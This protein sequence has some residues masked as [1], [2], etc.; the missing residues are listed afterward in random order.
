MKLKIL[1][2]SIA[3]MCLIIFCSVSAET[4]G[5]PDVT[6]HEAK[7]LEN[8]VNLHIEWQSVNPVTQV[9]VSMPNVEKEFP[10]DSYDNKRNPE[11][12]SGEMNVTLNLGFFPVQTF[13]YVIQ[14]QDELRVKSQPVT[15]QISPSSLSQTGQFNQ[16]TQPYPSST[17]LYQSGQYGQYYQSTP[18]YQPVQSG[19][20]GQPS[21][22]Q[23]SVMQ[24]QIQQ[25]VTQPPAQTNKQ[26]TGAVTMIISPFSVA[27]AGAMWRVDG[28]V[29]KKSG[30]TMT[31]VVVG[32][33]A[34]DF[35]DVS[36]WKKPEPQKIMIET[37]QN[38]STAA[39]YLK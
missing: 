27:D 10:V 28:G 25:N 38:V 23:P 20:S 16:T 12:Y 11:G 14:L 21:Q 19:Q 39:T 22:P 29:W 37:G 36:G 13:S 18:N 1:W 26:Q 24:I 4:A 7:F 30:E 31:D 35:L 34:I 32:V 2:N 3:V 6:R 33:H 8:A 9:K 15:G 17:P 5:K